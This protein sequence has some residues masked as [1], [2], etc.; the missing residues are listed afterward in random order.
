MKKQRLK[1]SRADPLFVRQRN[2]KKLIVA[3]YVDDGLIAGS[4][5]SE[6]DVFIDRVVTSR[7]RRAHSEISWECR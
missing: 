3:I 1:V 2:G 4:D 5:E 7:L 6:I